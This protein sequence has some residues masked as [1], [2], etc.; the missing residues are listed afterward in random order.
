MRKGLIIAMAFALMFTV[1]GCKSIGTLDA[2]AEDSI[3]ADGVDKNEDANTNDD[4][5]MNTDKGTYPSGVKE[6]T[7][8]IENK[9]AKDFNYGVA[10]T[11]EQKVDEEWVLVSPKEEI[12]V[13]EIAYILEGNGNATIV[14]NLSPYGELADGQ[15]RIVKNMI[16]ASGEEVGT[17]TPESYNVAAEFSIITEV[18]AGSSRLAAVYV[19]VEKDIYTSQDNVIKYTIGNN[20]DEPKSVILVPHLEKEVDDEWVIV[21]YEADFSGTTDTLIDKIEG[22]INLEWYPTISEGVYRLSFNMEENGVETSIL[23]DMFSIE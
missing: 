6:I 9:S 4:I 12:F 20:T 7:L 18:A 3:I 17:T 19:S 13:I 2:K 21:E 5:I 1:T 16:E 15:Y 14:S 23:A 8:T 10:F 11:L 22:E